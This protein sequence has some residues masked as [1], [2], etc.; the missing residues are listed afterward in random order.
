MKYKCLLLLFLLKSIL[1]AETYWT[2]ENRSKIT[3]IYK[4]LDPLIVKIEEPKRLYINR[5]EKNFTYSSKA[6]DRKKIKVT[7]EAPYIKESIDDILRKVYEYV[8]F[9]LE[10][11]G[12]FELFHED[13]SEKII[14]NAYFY[15]EKE[16]IVG[17]D[18]YEYKKE[19]YNNVAGNTFSATTDID[20][21]FTLENSNELPLGLYSGV[22]KLNVWFGGS[23]N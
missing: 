8:Y 20:V 11:G 21:D 22:L 15:D 19:F 16:S 2:G 14:G 4:V 12:K 17:K 6:E 18:I 10:T 5:S 7:V 3:I 13:G 1:F 23:I 9:Q